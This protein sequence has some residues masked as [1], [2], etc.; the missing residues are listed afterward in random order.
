MLFTLSFIACGGEKPAEAPPAEAPAAAPAAPAPAPA[1]GA[2]LSGVTLPAGV[3]QEMVQAGQTAWGTAVCAACHGP[4]AT[5]VQNMAPDLTDA[6]WINI[7][8]SYE[9][10]VKTINE[11][12]AKPKEHPT[13][14][15]PKGGNTAMTDQQVKELAAYIYAMSHKGA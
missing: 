7:D 12:V 11:G 15:P 10:I 3:T 13:P 1:G 8:G 5:G 14:M 4:Q 9:S 2:D 6:T